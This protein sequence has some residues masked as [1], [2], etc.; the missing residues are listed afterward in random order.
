MFIF[1]Q[2]GLFFLFSIFITLMILS[3][4]ARLH[5]GFSKADLDIFLLPFLLLLYFWM[6]FPQLRRDFRKQFIKVKSLD[7]I[8]A[9]PILLAILKL[10]LIY[11]YYYFPVL[12]GGDTIPL[13]KAQYIGHQELSR[14]GE[15]FLTGI[16][17]PF[18]EEFVFRFLLLFYV[19][20]VFLYY[21]FVKE[22]LVPKTDKFKMIAAIFLFLERQANKIYYQLFRAKNKKIIISWV[23]VCSF[24]FASVHGPNIY[25]FVLYF[26]PGLL[27]SYLFLR[28]GLLASWI[29]HGTSNILSPLINSIIYSVLHS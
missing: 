20:Y 4:N 28:Y 27:Y 10:V 19:P 17:G 24:L 15:I 9:I 2:V 8:I 5:L 16:L 12:F 26:V 22:P 1:K 6:I 11:S 7:R 3:I 25:S 14:T 29:A 13:G 21:I 23:I 18:T